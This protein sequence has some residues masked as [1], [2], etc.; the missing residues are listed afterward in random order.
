MALPD[1]ARCCSTH[2]GRGEGHTAIGVTSRGKPYSR[3]AR[4]NTGFAISHWVERSPWQVS[5]KRVAIAA[6]VSDSSTLISGTVLALKSAVHKS[7]GAS[8]TA[9][10]CSEPVPCARASM[11]TWCARSTGATLRTR[12]AR[13]HPTIA[14][15][16]DKD[17]RDGR[18]RCFSGRA[19][20]SRDRAR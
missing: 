13:A 17:Q 6:I 4:L 19:G 11:M 10:A 1:H 5:T 8:A 12:A 18:G 2:G 20:A 9:G 3:Y 14:N 15:L 16:L 7:L